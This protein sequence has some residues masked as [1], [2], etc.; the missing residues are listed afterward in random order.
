M[1]INMCDEHVIVN[2]SVRHLL[3]DKNIIHEIYHSNKEKWT[4]FLGN[5]SC[6]F[7]K[8]ENQQLKKICRIY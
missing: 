5:L 2:H 4:I 6:L 8:L 7:G 1:L 3:N